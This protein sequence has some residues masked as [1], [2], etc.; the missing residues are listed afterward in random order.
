MTA[1]LS[2]TLLCTS[3]DDRQMHAMLSTIN[4]GKYFLMV[5]QIKNIG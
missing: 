2:T 1:A 3:E 5:A 4:L